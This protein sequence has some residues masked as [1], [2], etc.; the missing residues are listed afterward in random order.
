MSNFVQIHHIVWKMK[1]TISL[2]ETINI[3]YLEK[4]ILFMQVQCLC[5][6]LYVK[7]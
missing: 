1:S 7:I 3:E 2:Y 5:N 6:N 4:Y